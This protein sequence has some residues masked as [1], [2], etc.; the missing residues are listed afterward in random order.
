MR[1]ATLIHFNLELIYLKYL[2]TSI[3]LVQA[4]Q[5]KWGTAT[6]ILDKAHPLQSLELCS[7]INPNLYY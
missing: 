2:A 3:I 5:A 4:A 7:E 1:D 6:K